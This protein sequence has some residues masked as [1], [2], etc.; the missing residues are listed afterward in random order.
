MRAAAK[1]DDGKVVVSGDEEEDE[2]EEKEEDI[3]WTFGELGRTEKKRELVVR[4]SDG[5]LSF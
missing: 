1:A 3:V 4:E 5:W 2:E